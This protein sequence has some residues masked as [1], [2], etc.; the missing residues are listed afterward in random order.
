M[1]LTTTI[2]IQ[3]IFFT[4]PP[5]LNFWAKKFQTQNVTREKQLKALWYEKLAH[6][7]LMKM[8]KAQEL[9]MH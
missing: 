1:K 5:G 7:M 9:G 8:T 3:L 4:C 2:Q 6:R